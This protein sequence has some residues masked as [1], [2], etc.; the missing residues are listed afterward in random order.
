VSETNISTDERIEQ[1]VVL[2]IV[3]RPCVSL[4]PPF[5][6]I[7]ADP[8]WNYT[9]F[10]DKHG[11][12]GE[13][14]YYNTMRL[15]D[16]CELP[17]KQI[18]ADDCA[19]F[20]WATLPMLPEALLTLRAWDFA[21]KTTAFVWVKE[22][23]SGRGYFFGMG[24]WTRSNTEICLLG[25]RGK[26]KRIDAS[27]SQLIFSPISKHSEKPH[28]VRDKIVELCGDVPRIELFARK[29]AQGWAAWG[30]QIESDVNLMA[31]AINSTHGG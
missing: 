7:Y 27:V 12:R 24:T 20:L 11:G 6:V 15:A 28:E 31:A 9:V 5:S 30:N 2:P 26:P 13:R 25:V 1:S 8:P 22:N 29:R 23:K 3:T 17:I 16:I 14:H 10:D 21:Y 19:L 18:A 4:Q